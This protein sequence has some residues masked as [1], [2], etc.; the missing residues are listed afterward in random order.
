[1]KTVKYNSTIGLNA[2]IPGKKTRKLVRIAY[3]E[4]ENGDYKVYV[5]SG[6][7]LSVY[8]S[9]DK[10]SLS[11]EAIENMRDDDDIEEFRNFAEL[12]NIKI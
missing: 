2:S 6:H 4:L 5:E 8:R 1:M 10:R 12:F 9:F 7:N 11:S 3:D